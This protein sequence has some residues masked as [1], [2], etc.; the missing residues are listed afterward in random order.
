[1]VKGLRSRDRR[2]EHRVG[3][4]R[5][6][7]RTVSRTVRRSRP[8]IARA[9]FSTSRGHSCPPARERELGSLGAVSWSQRASVQRG[10]S[11]ATGDF[12]GRLS[13][14]ARAV[15]TPQMHPTILS[16]ESVFLGF[17]W[18]LRSRVAVD[19]VPSANGRRRRGGS[20]PQRRR[21]RCEVSTSCRKSHRGWQH[22]RRS[23]RLPRSNVRTE[24]V[25]GS[26]SAYL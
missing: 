2:R 13:C 22:P 20:P 12:S 26:G 21:S 3:S 25:T 6:T 17:V 11:A 9:T 7:R 16:A 15:A 5:E 14:L 4:C 24:Q 10:R 1:M 23:Q 19:V 18:T 8:R